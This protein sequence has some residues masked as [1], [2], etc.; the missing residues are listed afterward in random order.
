MSRTSSPSAR[1]CRLRRDPLIAPTAS[2][3]GSVQIA[4]RV[5]ETASRTARRGRP[6]RAAGPRRPRQPPAAAG[7]GRRHGGAG[8][9]RRRPCLRRPGASRTWTP[10]TMSCASSESAC[11]RP[12]SKDYGEPF[13]KIFN[14]RGLRHRRDRPIALSPVV[15]R[16]TNRAAGAA[17]RRSTSTSRCWSAILG[18]TVAISGRV[19]AGMRKAATTTCSRHMVTSIG[20]CR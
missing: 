11:R 16:V 13:G 19:V 3:T 5:V 4:A 2:V 20:W 9:Y 18:L 14:R 1:R 8:A 7:R 12:S 17:S 6:R 15:I 10:T